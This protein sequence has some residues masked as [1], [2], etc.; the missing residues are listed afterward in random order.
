MIALAFTACNPD[1]R[2]LGQGACLV[3]GA[4]AAATIIATKGLA[5]R[6]QSGSEAV[7]TAGRAKIGAAQRERHARRRRRERGMG[8]FNELLQVWLS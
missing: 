4:G 6:R 2:S 5:Q 1:Y 7:G 8:G 3:I